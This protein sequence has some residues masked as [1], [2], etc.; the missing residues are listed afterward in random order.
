MSN[1]ILLHDSDFIKANECKGM[2]VRTI[3]DDEQDVYIIYDDGKW[4]RF[5]LDVGPDYENVIVNGAK[6]ES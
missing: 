1:V 2:K 3:V 4:T 6:C 5:T